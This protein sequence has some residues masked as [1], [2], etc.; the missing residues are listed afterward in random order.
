MAEQLLMIAAL[1]VIVA[2]ITWFVTNETHER[3][4]KSMVRQYR[5]AMET[6]GKANQRLRDEKQELID[7][8]S[9]YQQWEKQK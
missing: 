4:Y 8:L 9:F 7:E 2:L 3:N 1:V 6:L 5:D